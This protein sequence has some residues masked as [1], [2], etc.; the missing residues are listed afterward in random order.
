MAEGHVERVPI[1]PPASVMQFEEDGSEAPLP[2]PEAVPP[3]SFAVVSAP[4]DVAEHD[5]AAEDVWPLVLGGAIV[6]ASLVAASHVLER[7]AR[8]PRVSERVVIRPPRPRVA[9]P[10]PA[11][12][13]EAARSGLCLQPLGR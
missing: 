2:R 10:A 9:R 5:G 6:T 1:G 12:A 4:S 3:A 11:Y 8:R 7:R 13:V